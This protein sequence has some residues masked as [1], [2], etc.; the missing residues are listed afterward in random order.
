MFFLKYAKKKGF[1]PLIAE[2]WYSIS[3]GA[4]LKY[5]KAAATILSVYSGNVVRALGH[6]FPDIG[7]EVKKFI[8]MPSVS[9]GSLQTFSISH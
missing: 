9:R 6:L 1:D 8:S 7:L 5:S 4:L 2:N 3:V